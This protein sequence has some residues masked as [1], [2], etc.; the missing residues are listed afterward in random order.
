VQRNCRRD[1]TGREWHAPQAQSED[2][3]E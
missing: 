3:A 2:L 1:N